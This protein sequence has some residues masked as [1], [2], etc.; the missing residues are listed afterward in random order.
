MLLDIQ[1]DPTSMMAIGRLLSFDLMLEEEMAP[2]I[3][4]A[5]Q[6][7]ADAAIAN[8]WT[9]FQHPTGK[10]ASTI[11]PVM[12]SPLEVGIVVGAP[13]GFRLEYGFHGADSLG[14]IYDEAAEP[15]AGPALEAN[16]DKVM[17]LMD[18][19]VYRTWARVGGV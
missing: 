8:T 13:Q 19:A 9:A 2:S 11:E 18:S 6:I 16:A 17:E 12:V 7:V 10:M 1:F 3:D 5:G 14:R 15:Y 4:E